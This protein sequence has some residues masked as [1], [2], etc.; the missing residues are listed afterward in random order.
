MDLLA[1][2]KQCILRKE[3]LIWYFYKSQDLYN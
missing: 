1:I 3:K 2:E